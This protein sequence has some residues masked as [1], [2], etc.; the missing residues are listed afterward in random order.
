MDRVFIVVLSARRSRSCSTARAR[1]RSLSGASPI[2]RGPARSRFDVELRSRP[3]M[4]CQRG[5]RRMPR[6][7]LVDA[8]AECAVTRAKCSEN[9]DELARHAVV[10]TPPCRASDACYTERPVGLRLRL[11]LLLLVPMVLVVAAFAYFL[12]REAARAA[13]SGVRSARERHE[14]GDPA[15]RRE[16]APERHAGRRRAPRQGPGREADGDRPDPAAG[17]GPRAASRRE[18]PRR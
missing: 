17:P 15:G 9:A 18:P 5:A 10:R 3:S 16:R 6:R 8:N 11:V 14:R 2:R 4:E 7:T 1:L 13:A 12:V